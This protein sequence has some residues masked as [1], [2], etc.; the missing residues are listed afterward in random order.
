MTSQ[1]LLQHLFGDV[2][3]SEI[4]GEDGT[5][6]QIVDEKHSLSTSAVDRVVVE[7]DCSQLFEG[8]FVAAPVA[9]EVDQFEDFGRQRTDDQMSA[10]PLHPNACLE[11]FADVIALP[12]SAGF[13]NVFAFPD[14]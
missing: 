12:L 2:K 4:S 6:I 8:H 13:V 14:Q 9:E 1:A 7:G 11:V 10:P 5:R 3:L